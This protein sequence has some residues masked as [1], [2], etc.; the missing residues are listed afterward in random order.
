[1]WYLCGIGSNLAPVENVPAALCRLADLAGWVW[2]SPVVTTRPQGMDTFNGFLN[3]LV[4]FWVPLSPEELKTRLNAIEEAQG[5]DRSDPQRKVRDR[6]IDIDIIDHGPTPFTLHH[7]VAESYF[8]QVLASL[9]Q[10]RPEQARQLWIEGQP[11]GLQPATVYR[12][13][14]AGYKVVVDQ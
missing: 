9:D 5:R 2:A 14:G 3:A 10:E 12:D 8:A 1:M 7:A 13:G 6:P 4:L 11:L